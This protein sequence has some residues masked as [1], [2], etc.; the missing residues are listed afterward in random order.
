MFNFG[1]KKVAEHL[2]TPQW[3][4]GDLRLCGISHHEPITTSLQP[5][6]ALPRSD[7]YGNTQQKIHCGIGGC[8]LKTPLRLIG[9]ATWP[10]DKMIQELPTQQRPPI[11]W[12]ILRTTPTYVHGDSSCPNSSRPSLRDRWF[13]VRLGKFLLSPLFSQVA[14][15]YTR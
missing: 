15:S 5:S 3:T 12:S 14:I 11:T 1:G 13:I 2:Y 7:S 10:K 6:G 9:Q 8:R 4:F